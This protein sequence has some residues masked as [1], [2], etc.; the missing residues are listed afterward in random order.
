ML[1][2]E[3]SQHS[4][5]PSEEQYTLA[6]HRVSPKPGLSSYFEFLWFCISFLTLVAAV[7]SLPATSFLW[8][9]AEKQDD[10]EASVGSSVI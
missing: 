7:I 9:R 10:K 2:C 8:N 5:G 3:L 1:S 6:I 4:Q